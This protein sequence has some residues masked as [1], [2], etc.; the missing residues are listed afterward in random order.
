MILGM[1][2]FMNLVHETPIYHDTLKALSLNFKPFNCVMCS[3]FWVTLIVNLIIL[4][5]LAILISSITAIL[6]EII[7]IQIHKI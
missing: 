5:S 3:T 7:N 6:A 2:T 1:A 4:G